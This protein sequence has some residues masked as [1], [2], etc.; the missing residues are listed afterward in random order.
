F[1]AGTKQSLN[2]A[3]DEAARVIAISEFTKQ[4]LVE[5]A[6]VPAEE[7]QVVYC[8]VHEMFRQVKDAAAGRRVRGAYG[9]EDRPYILSVGFLDPR[10]NVNGHLRSFEILASKR[11]F[12]DLQ[13]VLVGPESNATDEVLKDVKS[14]T[15]RDRIHVTGYVP[16][17]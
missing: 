14:S 17:E 11:G 8:G 10:K 1:I 7:I 13:L 3:R 16:N 12:D 6:G 15:L 4:D 2:F 9:I 5:T